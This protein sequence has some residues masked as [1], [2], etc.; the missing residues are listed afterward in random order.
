MGFDGLLLLVVDLDL[1]GNDV[2]RAVAV[3]VW[4]EFEGDYTVVGHRVIP[5]K[6]A[7]LL[8][9]KTHL[10]IRDQHSVVIGAV[11]DYKR[12]FLLL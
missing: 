1:I 6:V 3:A 8:R 7:L 11:S 2:L 4:N 10:H 5:H 9:P 12:Y